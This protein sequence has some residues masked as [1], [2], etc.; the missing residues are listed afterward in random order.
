[1]QAR[2]L[3]RDLLPPLVLRGLRTLRG[4]PPPDAAAERPLG[5]TAA[6]WDDAVRASTGY[7][8][9]EILRRVEAATRQVV[10]GQAAFERDSVAFPHIEHPFPV[11]AGL[12]RAAAEADG[13]LT[14]LD[15]GGSLGSSYR[16]CRP[17]LAVLPRVHWMVVEQPHFVQAGRARYTTDELV[18]HAT[19]G[20][21]AAARTPHAVL[22][23]SS[24]Q[25]LPD[26]HAVLAQLAATGARTLLIDRTPLV[27]ADADRVIV[28]QVPPSIYPA[29]YP[30][31]IL[32]RARLLAA[33]GDGWELLADYPC[34]D[35]PLRT[36][37]GDVPVRGCILRRLP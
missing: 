25:Y 3:A 5:R 8:A 10:A 17:F 18:F 27:D 36:D 12:L 34:A 23:S 26:P 24:L 37:A 19:I 14:V 33:L 29:S 31:W 16:Q 2:A 28:Q 30:C 15:F 7:D 32:G 11:L 22:T 20:D 1:M 4:A 35:A 6:S 21:A 9:A 13:P